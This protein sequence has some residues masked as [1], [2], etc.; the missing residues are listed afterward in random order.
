MRLRKN[1]IQGIEACVLAMLCHYIGSDE[2]AILMVCIGTLIMTAK[3][4]IESWK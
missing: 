4:D 1:R 2:V 3:E